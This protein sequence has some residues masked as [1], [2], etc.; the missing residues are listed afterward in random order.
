MKL[1]YR[2]KSYKQ[3]SRQM[4]NNKIARSGETQAHEY[5]IVPKPDQFRQSTSAQQTKQARDHKVNVNNYSGYKL[6]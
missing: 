4:K 3:A 2:E 1:N 5:K 6:F